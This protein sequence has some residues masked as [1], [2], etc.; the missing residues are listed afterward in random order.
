MEKCINKTWEMIDL[1]E[2]D[3][4]FLPSV[5]IWGEWDLI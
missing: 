1:T 5:W 3:I 2:I 4:F